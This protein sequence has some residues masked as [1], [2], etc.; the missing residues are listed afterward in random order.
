MKNVVEKI[1]SEQALALN[2]VTKIELVDK[3]MTQT[4]TISISIL[5]ISRL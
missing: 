5:P 3:K 4:S 1:Q 2:L